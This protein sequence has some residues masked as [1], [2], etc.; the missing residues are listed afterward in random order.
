MIKDEHVPPVIRKKTRAS[1]LIPSVQHCT[2]DS[3]Q[4]SK[5]ER[6]IKA[7]SGSD[8]TL[9]EGPGPPGM[10]LMSSSTRPDI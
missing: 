5:Q 3:G 8:L 1:V 4:C 6:R 7:L 10:P 9:E 2:G